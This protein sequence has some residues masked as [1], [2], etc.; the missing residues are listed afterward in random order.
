[1]KTI[2]FTL[3]FL[4][5]ASVFAQK[6]TEPILEKQ[7]NLIKVT[8]YHDN[9]KIAQQGFYKDQKPHGEWKAFDV[10]GKKIAVATYTNGI[11]TG[12]W[13]FWNTDQLSEVDYKDNRIV[14]VTHWKNANPVVLN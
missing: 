8:F 9:G 12:K 5:S 6:S 11:K 10:T 2:L 14:A 4:L 1:M 3:V 13:F 7:G